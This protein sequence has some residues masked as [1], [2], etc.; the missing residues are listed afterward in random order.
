MDTP[1]YH[2]APLGPSTAIDITGD[3]RI[4]CFEEKTNRIVEIDISNGSNNGISYRIADEFN[5]ERYY[6]SQI[7]HI[8][9]TN[10]ILA[11]LK[12]HATKMF[13][14]VSFRLI[15]DRRVALAMFKL[16]TKIRS[17]GYHVSSQRLDGC[18]YFGFSNERLG[19][20]KNGND[21]TAKKTE[22]VI[23]QVGRSASQFAS[24]VIAN[25]QNSLTK[26]RYLTNDYRLLIPN[27]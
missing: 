19:R 18:C 8:H 5:F 17:D 13:W 25:D 1:H 22:S 16:K 20:K 14:L 11:L 6:W 24:K 26:I 21:G 3:G 7:V 27:Q 4:L 12:Y 9:S 15:D 23:L 2:K 10:V